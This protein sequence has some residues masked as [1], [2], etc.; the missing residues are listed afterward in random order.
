MKE[1]NRKHFFINKGLQGH[2]ILYIITT[3]FIISLVTGMCVYFA[4]WNSVIRDFSNE[5]VKSRL[6]LSTR[7]REYADARTT[8]SQNE[9]TLAMIKEFS[10]FA[11]REREILNDILASS[12]INLLPLLALLFF[13]IGWGSVFITH[14]V[15]GPIFRMQ[16]SFMKV[17]A[18]KLNFRIQLRK[19]DQARELAPL[20]NTLVEHLDKTISTIKKTSSSL[21]SALT[22]HSCPQEC[23]EL[24]QQ[25]TNEVEGYETSES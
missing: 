3:L 20:F 8:T 18:G 21:S 1:N 4:I 10:L 6:E 14:K 23:T 16:D 22:Q 2:Y 9:M 24:L 7:L 13:F 12:Y 17:I 15:A 19:Y 11:A 5:S 25:I